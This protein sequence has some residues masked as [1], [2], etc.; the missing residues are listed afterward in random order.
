MLRSNS[1]HGLLICT[2]VGVG[3]KCQACREYN[4][5]TLDNKDD[6]ELKIWKYFC[7]LNK[8]L[9]DFQGLRH[10]VVFKL[11]NKYCNSFYGSQA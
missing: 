6:I 11:F 9:S 2:E 5:S 1:S 3:S 7:Q 10:N 8:L 4:I